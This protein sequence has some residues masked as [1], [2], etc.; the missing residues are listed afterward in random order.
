LK[1]LIL[2]M[3]RHKRLVSCIKAAPEAP[4]H[5]FKRPQV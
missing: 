5:V 4:K 3:F 1:V 2:L